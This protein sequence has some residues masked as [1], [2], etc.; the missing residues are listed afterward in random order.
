MQKIFEIKQDVPEIWGFKLSG[1]ILLHETKKRKKYYCDG[2]ASILSCI[3]SYCLRS[4]CN[5]EIRQTGRQ[6]DDI[7]MWVENRDLARSRFQFCLLKADKAGLLLIAKSSLK[8]NRTRA[9]WP[10]TKIDQNKSWNG[11][12]WM[13]HHQNFKFISCLVENINIQMQV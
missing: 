11:E 5:S 9:F 12:N 1:I 13:I 2:S 8:R 3:V 4:A 10:T 6:T 7:M